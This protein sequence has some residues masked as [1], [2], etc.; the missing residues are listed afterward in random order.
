MTT[1]IITLLPD[2]PLSPAK[3]I[4][5]GRTTCLYENGRL[6]HIC[7][8]GAEI[9]QML[10]GAVRDEHWQTI[11]P[12]LS[13]ERL[14]I[15]DDHFTINY[16]AL[17]K[18]D[19][20]H[21]EAQF[22]IEGKS[23]GELVYAFEGI[24]R[25][26]FW[27]NRIGLC[28]HHPIQS[29]SGKKVEITRPGGQTEVSAF[30]HLVSPHQPFRNIS[31]MLVSFEKDIQAE[32]VFEGDIFETEDQRNWS[33]NSYKTYGTPLDLSFPVQVRKGDRVK[34][35]ITIR[36]TGDASPGKIIADV[37]EEKKV[38]FP[39]IGY[40]W[41]AQ[42]SPLTKLQAGRLL[43]IP[44]HHL[45]VEINLMK[46]GWK[47]IL[48]AAVNAAT[49]VNTALE[50]V[51]IADE[52]LSERFDELSAAIEPCRHLLS[53]VL[54]LHH[55]LDTFSAEEFANAYRLFKQKYTQVAVGYGTNGHFAELNR[56]RPL[57]K[58]HDFVAFCLSPQVHA[59]DTR[60]ILGNIEHQRDLLI[61]AQAFSSAPAH[62]YVTLKE[63]LPVND[64]ERNVRCVAADHRQYSSLVAYWTLRTIQQLAG[65]EQIS[66]YELMGATGLF[67]GE[68]V[69]A[70]YEVL[71]TLQSFGPAWIV[72]Q[73]GCESNVVVENAK[74]DRLVF[75][76]QAA[77]AL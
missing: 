39:K 62:V 16:S 21:F 41:S 59:T 55:R 31:K 52:K 43:K 71:V 22:S 30:P 8:Q 44:F 58:N 40:G 9:A 33:D 72:L 36:M 34:Q 73:T 25:N 51:I 53:G 5:A 60:S 35:R 19:A 14:Q 1:K 63:R 49:A 66:L 10:Y 47:E 15:G 50:L 57:D 2:V 38:R 76:L 48:P 26:D 28:I 46:A 18:R 17:Y 42:A 7:Y 23:N 27:K 37:P 32:I 67:T 75:E 64:N 20:I 65:A 61:T 74:G 29:C 3:K 69:S 4:R 70:L 77:G 68:S 11:E 56:N 12:L 24:A 13:G 6:R 54:L 45:R